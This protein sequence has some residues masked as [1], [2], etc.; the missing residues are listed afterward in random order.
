MKPDPNIE[1]ESAYLYNATAIVVDTYV[2]MLYR[3]QNRAKVSSIGIAWSIDGVSFCKHKNPI[4][5]ATEI[6]E[7]GGGVEDPRI[8]RD[9]ISKLFIVTYTAYDLKTAR[10]CVGTSEDLFHWRKYGPI[11]PSIW[12]DIAITSNGDRII[13]SNWSKSGAIFNEKNKDGKYYM[14]WGDSQLHLAES[15]D[16]KHWKVTSDSINTN[17]WAKQIFH[18]EN[19]LIESGPA[20]IKMAGA[21][22]KWIFFYN[23]ATTG[24]KDLPKDTYTV[25]EMLIDY[26]DL[27]SG[28]LARLERPILK[29]ELANELKGQ[30]NHVVFCEG[31]VQFKNQWFLY[32]GQGDSELGV[33]MAPVT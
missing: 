24:G 7:Q 8:V 25:N 13:R 5:T 22:N 33:A 23:A 29:P 4:L 28:P 9:P 10:L 20:P 32:Y 1:W 12:N 17:T 19:K 3:A 31:I 30:V 26:D 15:Q 27:K 2:F 21:E 6:Y 14:I 16:L 11:V 18:R